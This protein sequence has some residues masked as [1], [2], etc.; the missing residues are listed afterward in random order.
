M[1]FLRLARTALVAAV[2]LG[3]ALLTSAPSNAYPQFAQKEKVSCVYCHVVPGGPRN[4]RGKYYKAHNN[5]FADFD[6]EYEA[7]LAGVKPDSMGADAKATVAGYP[8]SD[9]KVPAVLN[10]IVKDVD[11]KTVNLAR[12]Q[13]DVIL[14]VNVASLCGNTP[15]YASLQKLYEQYKAKGF[16]I[17]GFPANNF[18]QQE[19]GSNKEIKEFC[20]SKYHVSFPIFSKI[21]VKGDDQAPLYKFLTSKETNP[22]FGGDIE[23]NFAKFLVN[24]KGEVVARFKAGE[25]PAKPEV[26]AAIERE[27]EAPKP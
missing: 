6:N 16:V 27:L 17:L 23:W 7:S 26:V 1:F 13:G 20:T 24:R 2:T 4:F 18:G 21:S 10:F 14:L 5:S 22:K 19:P 12:Y 8:A 11:G 3:M 15:Q 25:D 9:K